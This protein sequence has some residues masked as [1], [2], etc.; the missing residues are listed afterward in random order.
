MKFILLTKNFR[1]VLEYRNLIKKIYENKILS[2]K[3]EKITEQIHYQL[4]TFYM[5]LNN[6][7]IVGDFFGKHALIVVVASARYNNYKIT[8]TK[9]KYIYRY[10]K[11]QL[12]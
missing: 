4:T 9:K 2:T 11:H 12:F 7:K 3:P 5:L 1:S 10:C 6:Y 8:I